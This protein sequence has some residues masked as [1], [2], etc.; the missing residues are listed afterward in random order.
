MIWGLMAIGTLAALIYRANT[1]S[2]HSHN[3]DDDRPW[4][5]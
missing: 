3:A 2:G 1:R 5:W 4:D